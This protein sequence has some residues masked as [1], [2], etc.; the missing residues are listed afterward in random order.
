M[1]A[2]II[3]LQRAFPLVIA[4]HHEPHEPYGPHRPHGHYR[5]HVPFGPHTLNGPHKLH[6]PRGPFEHH[7]NF[8]ELSSS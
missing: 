3:A 1:M 4:N 6:G 7:V 2:E 5:P 8:K